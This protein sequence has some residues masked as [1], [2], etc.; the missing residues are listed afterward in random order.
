MPMPELED[1]PRAGPLF[2]QMDQWVD[3]ADMANAQGKTRGFERT[4]KEQETLARMPERTTRVA[5]TLF[6][7]FSL[8]KII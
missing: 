7:G 3:E 5:V 6:P 1:N 2:G 4:K 8:L